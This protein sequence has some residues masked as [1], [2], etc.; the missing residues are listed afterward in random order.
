MRFT[1]L[2]HTYIPT[3]VQASAIALFF[4]LQRLFIFGQNTG[5]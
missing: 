4:A 3:T 2:P 5:S 1:G